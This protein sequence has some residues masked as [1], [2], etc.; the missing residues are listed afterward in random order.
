LVH[1]A[2]FDGGAA[3]QTLQTGDLFTLLGD[4]LFQGGNFAA[5]FNHQRFKLWAAQIREGRWR[6][7]VHT[8]RASLSWGK[9]KMQHRPE[10]CPYY[11][12]FP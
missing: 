3:R 9:R 1:A 6:W 10:F 12:A 4:S 7:H 8:D 2:R 11:C 5:Q